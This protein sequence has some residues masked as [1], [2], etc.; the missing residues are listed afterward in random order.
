LLARGRSII[1]AV[2]EAQA[3]VHEAIVHAPNIGHGHGPLHHMH[4]WYRWGHG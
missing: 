2:S 4:P 3:Y 1:D